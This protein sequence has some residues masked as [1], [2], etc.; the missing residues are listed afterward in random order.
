MVICRCHRSVRPRS[1]RPDLWLHRLRLFI[2]YVG[3]GVAEVVAVVVFVVVVVV[4][5]VVAVIAVVVVVVAD[6]VLC[7]DISRR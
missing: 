5:A 2:V 1:A 3:A 6:R 4:L 7:R